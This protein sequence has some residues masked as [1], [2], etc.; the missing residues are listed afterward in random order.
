MPSNLFTSFKIKNVEFKNRIGMSPMCQYSST[1]GVASDWHMVHLGARAV[2]GVGF[3]MAECTAVS[4]TGRI[5]QG[6][7]GLWN[8]E[9]VAALK[10]IVALQRQFGAV[11]G[12]QISHSG[13]KGSAATALEGGKMSP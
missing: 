3:I 9:Q 2:G 11:T 10:P 4:A 6:C 13:R 1:D 8:V 5:S 7:A 12:I